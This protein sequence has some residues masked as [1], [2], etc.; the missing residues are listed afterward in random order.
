MRLVLCR[1]H[2]APYSGGPGARQSS[3][4]LAERLNR[5]LPRRWRRTMPLDLPTHFSGGQAASHRDC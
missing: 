2:V 1:N 3:S 5:L 4:S